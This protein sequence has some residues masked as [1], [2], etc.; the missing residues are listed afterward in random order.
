MKVVIDRELHD[1]CIYAQVGNL[2]KVHF[3]EQYKINPLRAIA[4]AYDLLAEWKLKELAHFYGMHFGDVD[5]R[6][7]SKKEIRHTL[8]FYTDLVERKPRKND[9][10]DAQQIE[11]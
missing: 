4:A 10:R 8:D 6:V 9:V 2:A 7:V 1:E 11:P 3:A 5:V